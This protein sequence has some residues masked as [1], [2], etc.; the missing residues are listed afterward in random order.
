[1]NVFRHI[2][3]AATLVAALGITTTA[4]AALYWQD[5]DP[6]SGNGPLDLLREGSDWSYTSTF[7]MFGPIAYNSAL[8]DITKI[9]VKFAFADDGNDTG[10][11]VD[12]RVGPTKL[13]DNAEVDG[14]HSNA[15]SSYHWLEADVT[16][17]DPIKTDLLAD[18]V[19]D[20]KV[21]IQNL[22]DW[23]VGKEDTYLKIAHL[24]VWGD[25]KQVP[26]AGATVALLGLGLVGLAAAR[27]RL[28]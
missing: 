1:M 23:C 15:P 27:R 4:S 8:H 17:S 11:Y 28:R 6:S 19:I 12:I 3:S 21:T 5:R 22:Q 16:G 14:N 18:G 24:E 2:L 9:V 10:E 13:W 26:D 25:Y 7:Q 20:Y